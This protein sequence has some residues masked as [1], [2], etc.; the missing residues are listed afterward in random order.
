MKMQ[1][2]YLARLSFLLL[3]FLLPA[4]SGAQPD[5]PAGDV[6]GIAAEPETI[7]TICDGICV[8]SAN[9]MLIVCAIYFLLLLLARFTWIVLPNN[10]YLRIYAEEVR[11]QLVIE[12][13]NPAVQTKV[14][15]TI[16]PAIEKLLDDVLTLI[17]YINW[18]N[19]HCWLLA[20]TG[21][22]LAC[23]RNVH[24]AKVFA[25]DLLSDNDARALAIVVNQTLA[26]HGS[27]EGKG[28]SKEI[29]KALD[30]GSDIQ[31]IKSLAKHGQEFLFDE[32]DSYFQGLASW[33]N[34]ATWLVMVSLLT[35][36]VLGL[37]HGNTALFV[38]GAVG[39]LLSRMRKALSRKEYAFDY[40]ASWST[41]FLAPVVGAL[42]GWVG[43][44]LVFVLTEA[45]LLGSV[46]ETILNISVIRGIPWSDLPISKEAMAL[47]VAFGFSATFFERIMERMESSAENTAEAKENDKGVIK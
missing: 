7:P 29:T 1:Y 33:Q 38:L 21:K 6:A 23:W 27:K 9:P 28:L 45:H 3:I 44:L 4:I 13:D 24:K 15:E 36:V 5:K 10:Q 34:R 14:E 31:M 18:K 16:K 46:F 8:S 47:A 17:P 12:Q 37:T 35:V 32:R 25:I 22:Q 40:G 11:A 26:V 20:G 19:W 41:L 30:D 42:T 39:G 43:V 2:K